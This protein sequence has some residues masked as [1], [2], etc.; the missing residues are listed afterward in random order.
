M[1]Y[2]IEE[3]FS[4]FCQPETVNV[5]PVSRPTPKFF[6]VAAVDQVVVSC[7]LTIQGV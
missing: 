1:N 2:V 3:M 6:N 5:V 4:L 7:M